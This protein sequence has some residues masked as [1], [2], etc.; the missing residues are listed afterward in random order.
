MSA[1]SI[2]NN[3]CWRL[4]K[5]CNRSCEF[6]LSTSNSSYHDPE[7]D[8]DTLFQRF[9]QLNI[10]KISYAGGEPTLLKNIEKILSTGKKK[11]FTQVLTS[12]G[13]Y[14]C[15]KI[16]NWISN[17][18]YIRFSFYGHQKQHDHIM[19]KNHYNSLLQLINTL[20]KKHNLPVGANI[21]ISMLSVNNLEMILN[22]LSQLDISQV[23]LLTY[24][25]TE[26]ED[27]DLK[28]S[29]LHHNFSEFIIQCSEKYNSYFK[30]GIRFIDFN[31]NNFYIV[32][33][34]NGELTVPDMNRNN[35]FV[36]GNI[37]NDELCH[38]SLG[39]MP[40]KLALEAIWKNRDEINAI[41][42]Y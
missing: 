30:H 14:L 21:M 12:N 19:G 32:L 31:K 29:L 1:F 3:I 42:E 23:L 4:T 38:P 24:I 39:R 6:C 20:N 26:I 5:R 34:E 7:I 35:D 22:D 41:T 17:L 27:I 8:I 9:E 33:N 28:Y 18:D 11:Y 10:E 40:A 36:M 15:R 2:K 16:P 25:P 13:D 37:L